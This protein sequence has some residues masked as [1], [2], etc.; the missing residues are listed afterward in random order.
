MIAA[1]RRFALLLACCI[2]PSS[3]SAH[4]LDEY[5]QATIV[6]IEPGDIRNQI[7]LTPGVAVAER[8]LA[9][10][11]R[12]RDGLISTNE[13]WAYAEMLRADLRV[14]I[15][16]RRVEFGISDFNFTDVSDLHTGS[17]IVQIEFV[18][19]AKSLTPGPHIV[20]I[21][22]HH[23]PAFSVY[24]INAA[25]PATESIQITKQARNK[26]QSR[27]KIHFNVAALRDPK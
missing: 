12:N 20:G 26:N 27:G 8:V 18:L 3:L 5:L 24:L 13:A 6:S 17:G 10:I 16:G 19:M 2:L 25:Q 11:D 22:N 1:R 23:L 14:Q 9:L 15:G 4:R 21:A 7:N